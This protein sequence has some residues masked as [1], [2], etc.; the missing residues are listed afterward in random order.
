MTRSGRRAR[1]PSAGLIV[2]AVASVMVVGGVL[3]VVATSD[4]RPPARTGV[5][6][7]IEPLPP[8]ALSVVA[9][10]DICL[11]QPGSCRRTA[12]IIDGL[13][14]D[15]V[16]ALGDNQY[17]DGTID[18]YRSSY[19]TTWGAFLDI[20]YPVAGNH[21]WNT[22]DAQ[23]FVDYFGRP[24][25][26]T[27]VIGDWRFYALDGTC[28]ENGGCDV[29]DPQYEW[30]A[31]Q[32][33]QR[34]DRC[35]V[36][37]WHQPRFSSGSEHGSDEAVAGLWTLLERAGAD[38]VLNGHEHHYER[39]VPQDATGSPSPGGIVEIVVGTGGNTHGYPFGEPLPTSAMRLEELGVLELGLLE[40][41][42]LARFVKTSGEVAD[43]A[44][45]DC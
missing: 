22:D 36:A 37:F 17:P 12:T 21:E 29:G 9:A 10:G 4:E 27:F 26:Y 1:T 45:G 6:T 7:P 31:A 30:L 40:D 19:D 44:R 35:I 16:L 15:A 11:P 38:L 23:G 8:D 13:D 24:Y 28:D 34:S 33:E 32:L 20:T 39:F 18:E 14:P 25:W 5:A 3:L 43:R 42:W 2:A 41:A